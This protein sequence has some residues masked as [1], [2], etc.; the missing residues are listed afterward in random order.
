MVSIPV[1]YSID[2]RSLFGRSCPKWQHYFFENIV[3][4]LSYWNCSFSSEPPVMEGKKDKPICTQIRCFSPWM[5]WWNRQVSDCQQIEAEG[6]EGV[7]EKRMWPTVKDDWRGVELCLIIDPAVRWLRQ[8]C[9]WGF[10]ITGYLQDVRGY[11]LLTFLFA[12]SACSC[13][14]CCL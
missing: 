7:K 10:H 5:K 1:A 11:V 3:F 2:R 6:G 4:Y 9:Y 13:A 14:V 12:V 8:K